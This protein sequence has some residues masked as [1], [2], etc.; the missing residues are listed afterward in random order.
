LAPQL[1]KFSV[2]NLTNDFQGR[3]LTTTVNSGASQAVTT[4]TYDA[5][6]QVTKVTRPDGSFLTYAYN[7]ARRLTTVTSNLGET[8]TYTY[9]L[10][11]DVASRVLKTAGGTIV[12][13]QTQTFD[14]LGRL[15]RHIGANAQNTIYAYD[16]S[17]LLT[18][19][20]DPRGGLYAYAT[21]VCSA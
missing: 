12:F 18:S 16:K 15:L 17:S 11:G 9:D 10:N 8:I 19:V 20:T 7:N 13:N 6:G 14:E 3:L 1:P 21:T 2:T 5:I 4:L